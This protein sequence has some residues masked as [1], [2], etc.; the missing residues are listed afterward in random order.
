MQKAT[1]TELKQELIATGNL[2]DYGTDTVTLVLSISDHRHRAKVRFYRYPS[3]KTAWAAVARQLAETPQKSWVRLEAVQS[4]QELPRETF[5]K[6]LAATFRMNYWRYG[7]SF[8]KDFKTAL[9]EMESNGQAFFRPSKEH[10]IGKNRSGSWVD[11]D[12]VEPYLKKREGQLPVDIRQTSSVWVFT[13]AGV[14]TD[15]EKIW[16]LSEREDCGKGI[17]VVSDEQTELRDAIFHGETFLVNQL[18]D[19]GKFVYGYFPARQKVLS[20]YN[21][22]RHFSSLYALLEAIPF[23]NRTDDYKKVKAAIQWGLENATIE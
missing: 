21:V 9:L 8:D 12:R 17:R 4:T 2:K 6:R 11:Y 20:N 22:V 13:T 16:R 14:F 5:E 3:F 15:G 18:K 10:R 19:N 7:V 23:T 1:V